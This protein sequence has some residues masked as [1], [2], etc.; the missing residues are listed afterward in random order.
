[1]EMKHNQMD[2][3]QM[4]E[5][6][7]KAFEQ[8][9]ENA[10]KNTA[11]KSIDV[12]VSK[13][14]NEWSYTYSIAVFCFKDYDKSSHNKA[15]LSTLRTPAENM[16]SLV[17]LAANVKVAI[18]ELVA[19][20]P[21]PVP[22]FEPTRV[23]TPVIIEAHKDDNGDVDGIRIAVGD[24]DFVLSLHDAENPSDENNE[25]KWEKAVAEHELP[26]VK[27]ARIIAAYL[28]EIQTALRDN[29]GDELG[30]KW[31]WTKSEYN[32]NYTWLYHGNIGSVDNTSKYYSY[33]VRP[34]LA[35]NA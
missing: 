24:E 5:T 13:S 33:S 14:I 23:A 18:A 26:T 9:A 15:D 1:M 7:R 19:P 16:F 32:A 27:Q 11:S 25:F 22:Q 29:G 35:S 30:D 20:E 8:M 3:E 21:E 10:L 4:V 12:S 2:L 31:Y 17:N 34:V 6:F 28:P